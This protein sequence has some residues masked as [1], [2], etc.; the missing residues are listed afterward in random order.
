MGLRLG[1]SFAENFASYLFVTDPDVVKTMA[2]KIVAAAELGET[3]TVGLY[4]NPTIVFPARSY[5]AKWRRGLRAS[6]VIAL[7]LVTTTAIPARAQWTGTASSDW[8]DAS[9]W[10]TGVPTNATSTRID[11]VSPNATVIGA[12]GAQSTG[13]RVGVSGTGALT[14]QNGGT[15]N[16]TLG[17]I[18]DQAGSTGTV[19]V[20]GA[21]ST[22]A[23]NGN[24]LYV[25]AD[26][27]GT[28]MIKNGGTVSNVFGII[29]AYFNSTGAVTVDGAG[30]NWTNSQDLAVGGDGDGNPNTSRGTLTISNGGAVSSAFGIIGYDSG[31]TGV[32]TVDG[33]G[34]TWTNRNDLIFGALGA[35]SGTLTIS[36]G[37]TVSA[38]TTSF[39]SSA[40]STS[41]LNIGAA[42]GQAA[43]A[44][45]TLN[46]ASVDFGDGTGQ[47]VFNHTSSNYIF[48]P[49]I[50][51][52]GTGTGSVL[53]EAGTTTLTA[54][55]N[56]IRPTIIDGG[57]LS[58]NGSIAGSSVTV[59]AGGALGGKGTVGNT[60]INGGTL[61]PSNSVG[62]LTVNGNLSFTAASSYVVGVS[63]TNADRTNVTGTASLGG[64]SVNANFAPG[65]YITKQYTILNATG[66]L[67][68][69]TFGSFSTNLP[70]DF[71]TSLSYD[72]NNAYLDLTLLYVG[73]PGGLNINQTNVANTLTD[74]FNRNGGIPL[75]YSGLTGA[76]LTQA[77]GEIA[78][79]TQQTSFDAMSQFMGV[80]TDPLG[81]QAF[82][83]PPTP[84]KQRWNIWATGFGG[85]QTTNGNVETGS[86]SA[87]SNIYATAVGADYLFS[88]G[89]VAGFAV[90]G[91]GTNFSVDG[92]G[93]GRSNLYQLG[94]HVRHTEGPAYISAALADGWQDITTNR[95]VTIAGTDQLQARF[96]ANAFS[97]RVEGG[98]RLAAPVVGL[99]ITPYAAGQVTSLD[100]PAYAEQVLTGT[101]TF[102]LAYGAQN[103]IDTRS[104]FGLR[105]DKSFGVGDAVLTLGGRAAWAHDFNT[106]R[107]AAASFQ[108]L[109]G[110]S[111]IVNGAAQA[112][113]SVL[114]TASVDM[115]WLNGL[116]AAASIEGEFSSLS[117]SYAGKGVVRYTWRSAT[118][119]CESESL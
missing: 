33:A 115:K 98:Y 119:A 5:F 40:G 34:S 53:V 18:G 107:S 83:A 105:S 38:A 55:S 97:G 6:S 69:T 72:A 73:G 50:T 31:S 59:N 111:F 79:R 108:A 114:T 22:W 37:G 10:S 8:F 27:N 75:V 116:S 1:V 9:N 57:M 41:T 52:S 36:N 20:T 92:S 67:G 4:R 16:N 11:T 109:S 54:I 101:N 43:V 95:T 86:N 82:D 35:A 46:T 7:G 102:A 71:S 84:F 2:K 74:Y 60:A 42:V 14:I 48:S 99:G 47:I 44:P 112:N 106:D 13:L 24:D 29:G 61:A 32:V 68:G 96:N 93:T 118:G 21:G 85:S 80:M 94:A 65:A 30:S 39:A 78:T 17:I 63:A 49:T 77:S 104:E 66:G 23:N 87:T 25:G 62:Q 103:V 90:G 100:L 56:Y 19:V 88:P 110:T 12:P 91:G 76:G 45:G 58:V 26:G 113:D 81:P 64:A 51:S 15:M 70:S 117:S 89:T 3:T 28:L